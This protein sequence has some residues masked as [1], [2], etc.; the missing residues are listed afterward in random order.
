V[1]VRARRWSL[2]IILPA[3]AL[4][5]LWPSDA[6]AWGPAAHVDH[7][8]EILESLALLPP[9]LRQLL[10]AHADDFLYGCCAADIVVGKNM[11]RYAH[12]CHNWQ[13]GLRILEAARGDRQRAFAHGFLAHLAA[14]VIAH[15]YVIPFKIVE[16]FRSMTAKHAY[17]EVR[18]DKAALERPGVFMA[19][20]KIGR[21]HRRREHDA[22]L[23]THLKRASRLFSFRTSR[24]LFSSMMFLTRLT[25]WQ[26]IVG[27]MAERSRLPLGTEEVR[28]ARRLSINSILSLLIDGEHGRAVSVDPTGARSL[29]VARELRRELRRAWRDGA[30]TEE[31][32]PHVAHDLRRRFREG[33]YAR[34]DVPHVETLLGRVAR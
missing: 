26:R 6:F 17:W 30:L 1:L 34:L 20:R 31:S 7:G 12:H 28:E 14:D 11:A 16:S 29:R 32:W 25:R 10:S 5:L 23:A 24:S 2:G 33:I 19:L 27:H 8:L 21:G 4:I 13:V 15:N 22:F 3:A 18:F 9:L